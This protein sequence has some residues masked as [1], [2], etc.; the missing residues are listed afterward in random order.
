MHYPSLP[1]IFTALP[2]CLPPETPLNEAIPQ[3]EP[4]PQP[5]GIRQTQPCPVQGCILVVENARLVGIL[6]AQDVVRGVAMGKLLPQA[7][8][9][10]VMARQVIFISQKEFTPMAAR[11]LLRQ[12]QMRYL[13]VVDEQHHPI[14][15]V[16]PE[17]LLAWHDEESR[18][19]EFAAPLDWAWQKLVA[20][21]TISPGSDE[22]HLLSLLQELH[23]DLE[24]RVE[25]RTAELQAREAELQAIINQA[26]VGITLVRVADSRYVK[27]NQQFCRLLGYQ[28]EELLAKTYLDTTEPVDVDRDWEHYRRLLQ[29]EANFCTLEKRFLHKAGHAIW[30]LL[31]VSVV[32][33]AAGEPEYT[34]GIVQDIRPRKQA[35]AA[36]RQRAEQD[37]IIALMTQWIRESL[38]LEH[39]LN[40]AVIAVQKLLQSDR[41]L[42]Y[43]ILADGTGKVIAET[44]NSGWRSVL[45]LALPVEAFPPSC[46]QR[47]TDGFVYTM[48]DVER[49]K[50]L[51][52]L[53]EM[54]QDLQV[55]AKLV[56]PIVQDHL[57]GLMIVHQC[58]QPRQWQ[59]SDIE[60]LK[61]VATQLAIAI[62]Q[63]ELYERLQQ[64]LSERKTAQ[65]QLQEINH[66]LLQMNSELARATRLKDEF[67]ANMSHELR[68][69]LNAI[70]GISEGLLEEV[71]GC[72]NEHQRKAIGTVEKSGTHLLAL[73]NDILELAKI[74]SGKLELN[75][76]LVP[77][78]NLCDSSLNV[79][80][81]IAQKK[82]IQLTEEIPEVPYAVQVDDVRMR[83]VL[84]NLLSNAIKFTPEGGSVRLE[85]KVQEDQ[86]PNST[87]SWIIFSVIDTGIGIAQ[88]NLGRLFQAFVQL[89]S[90]LS[91]QYAGTGLGLA[92]VRQIVQ[93]HGGTVTVSS[94]LEKGSCFQVLLPHAAPICQ[95]DRSFYHADPIS[96]PFLT[97]NVMNSSEQFPLI[98]L[99]ED[100]EA[101]VDTISVYLSS[102]GYRLILARNGYEAVTMARTEL[103]DLVLMD[104]Q[105]PGLDG[106][107]A[108]RQIRTH[109]ELSTLPIIALTA[110]AMAGDR[111]RCLEAG[112][113]EYLTKPVRLK[114][115]VQMIEQL[116]TSV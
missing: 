91:R 89:D 18:D 20:A 34:V 76:S 65:G 9:A 101:N 85:V 77:L 63:S 93:L 29:G 46:H 40:T 96:Q 60:L 88:E 64:E 69:P 58:S 7:V 51:P 55:Q 86:T 112:A 21:T 98:L 3:L 1:R 82:Q 109:P 16:T 28:A 115:L 2:P 105:M 23:H 114:H 50:T 95:S 38:S 12:H 75:L 36:L 53:R 68:T 43:Q 79:V 73:I 94:E 47:Y 90:C 37:R 14:G 104:I 31:T 66:Q 44:V 49:V 70:L 92:L 113:T 27:V 102:R 24:T 45:H 99:A 78:R 116:W 54:M 80:R 39:I 106:L 62:Q 4:Q 11:I 72:L 81:L 61:Q 107:E 71:Y 5:G 83:Q 111:E 57:W 74:E 41:V 48:P 19:Q 26:A 10:E 15:L 87:G 25:R 17:A 67:L 32:R 6:T 97:S 22:Q 35:E 33:N 56:I 8:I 100:N 59:T 52:C 30:T 42:I 103:P 108:I 110:L 13:P 84:I